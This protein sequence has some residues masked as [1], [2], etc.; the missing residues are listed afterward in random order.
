[1]VR[2]LRKTKAVDGARRKDAQ[3]ETE[4]VPGV[5]H[6]FDNEDQ[7]LNSRVVYDAAVDARLRAFSGFLASKQ[8]GEW[9]PRIFS[10]LGLC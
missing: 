3:L 10:G 2:R 9:R 7:T 5:T 6:G 8:P 4:T 1:M